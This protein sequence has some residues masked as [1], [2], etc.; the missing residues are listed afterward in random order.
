[1][2]D[3]TGSL[4]WPPPVE[5]TRLSEA[6]LRPPRPPGVV[7]RFWARHPRLA[8][9]LIALAYWLPAVGFVLLMTIADAE[10]VTP[11][12]LIAGIAVLT[13][14]AGALLFRRSRPW[15][16]IIA[17]WIA[18]LAAAPLLEIS[19]MGL[20]PFA[21]YGVA[22]YGRARNAWIAYGVSV[23][24]AA[25]ATVIAGP[26]TSVDTGAFSRALDGGVPASILMAIV[27]LIAINIGNRRRYVSALIDRAARLER[28]RVQL[29]QLAAL[30]ERSRIAREMHDIVS[31]SL[32]VMVT[33][34][35]G[36]AAIAPD[37]AER[38]QDGMRRV[39]ETGRSALSDMR[40]MLGVLAE[41]G[42]G[43]T[44]A[45]LAPQPGVVDLHTLVERF[46][47][48]GLPVRFVTRGAEPTDPAAQLAVYRIVQESLTNVLKHADSP[49]AVDVDVRFR[50]A[51]T[52]IDVTDDGAA[53]TAA[54]SSDG[55]GL[56][57]M[58]ERVAIYGGT[59]TSG[60]AGT[61]GWRVHASLNHDRNDDV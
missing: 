34:A 25:V 56:V 55:H 61:R 41:T 5:G 28:E 51:T 16:P 14:G 52:T 46:R 42:E 40:R 58:R 45:E 54:A 8:D 31:H 26:R 24:V 30:D 33:L 48:A 2:N 43:G 20:I 6:E 12:P 18:T 1:V 22:I 60:P 32:T 38:A 49:T 53:T 47:T 10:P 50:R 21:L 19:D 9:I 13:L 44:V 17:A 39:A 27:V 4:D 15:I 23:P 11:G 37:D 57:G 3:K 59:L 7:R 29:A 35:E 36:S